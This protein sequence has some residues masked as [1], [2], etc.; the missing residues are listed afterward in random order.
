LQ[1]IIMNFPPVS[2]KEVKIWLHCITL[3]GNSKA[4]YAFIK[5][6]SGKTDEAIQPDTNTGQVIKPLPLGITELEINLF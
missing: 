2:S 5:M 6:K 3:E 1:K 4:L